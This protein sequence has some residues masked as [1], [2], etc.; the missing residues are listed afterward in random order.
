MSADHLAGFAAECFL[1]AILLHFFDAKLSPK[2]IPVSAHPGRK[3]TKH[4]HLPELWGQ[5]AMLA[6]GRT[7]AQFAAFVAGANPFATW[8]VSDRY[9]DGAD[10]T[11]SRAWQHVSAAT[12][13]GHLYQMAQIR[14]AIP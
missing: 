7:G 14:G 11:S 1:K 2:G 6:A 4:G 10:I 12:T 13:I 9:G 8:D 3:P 5:V